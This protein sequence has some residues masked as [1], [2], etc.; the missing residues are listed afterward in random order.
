MAKFV[1]ERKILSDRARTICDRA[2]ALLSHPPDQ[3][4]CGG[5][6]ANDMGRGRTDPV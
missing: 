3:S 5:Q 1:H 2:S 6:V 4:R